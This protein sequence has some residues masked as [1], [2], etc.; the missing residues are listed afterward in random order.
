M[1]QLQQVPLDPVIE[2]LNFISQE[3][4]EE[5]VTNKDST[6]FWQKSMDYI[7]ENAIP[8]VR[9]GIKN[10]SQGMAEDKDMNNY[11]S[12]FVFRIFTQPYAIKALEQ[13]SIGFDESAND[14]F[15]NG[16]FDFTAKNMTR[17][18]KLLLFITV[19][20]NKIILQLAELSRLEEDARQQARLDRRGGK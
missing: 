11:F 13:F 5:I 17:V 19:H 18:E 4:R 8:S 6:N 3:L 9:E 10:L 14:A 20:R 7:F 2:L 15:F 12:C 1:E 16:N